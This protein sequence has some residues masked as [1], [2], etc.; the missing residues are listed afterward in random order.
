[1]NCWAAPREIDGFVGAIM[2][3]ESVNCP[4][5]TAADLEIWP[6]VA[7]MVTEPSEALVARPA[8]PGELPTIAMP[9]ALELQVTRAVKSCSVPS[10]KVPVARNCWVAPR[11]MEAEGGLSVIET[12]TLEVTVKFAA[13]LTVPLSAVIVVVPA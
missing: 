6:S 9:V 5:S 12:R 11:G 8:D 4:T 3:E 13:A 10:L 7:E 1:M 2:M